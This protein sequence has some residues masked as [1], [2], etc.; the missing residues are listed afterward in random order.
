MNQ[1]IDP[2]KCYLFLYDVQEQASNGDFTSVVRV[3]IESVSH[4]G[5]WVHVSYE[6]A[7][8]GIP[9]QQWGYFKN[10]PRYVNTRLLMTE[11]EAILTKKSTIPKVGDLVMSVVGKSAKQK[12]LVSKV[13]KT[14]VR[15]LDTETGKTL[16]VG[17]SDIIVI[18][19]DGKTY[20]ENE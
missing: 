17:F 5:N 20:D 7:K 13:N 10:R 8:T 16:T 11:E 3:K 2:E 18:A 14:T 12:Y 1:T 9:Y 6:N 19:R 4:C 15:R